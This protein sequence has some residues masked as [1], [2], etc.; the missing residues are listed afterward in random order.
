MGLIPRAV[1]TQGE[2]WLDCHFRE[3]VGGQRGLGFHMRQFQTA[4]DESSVGRDLG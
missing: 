2:T 1:G 4:V 3:A